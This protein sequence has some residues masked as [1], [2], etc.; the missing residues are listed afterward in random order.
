MF[1]IVTLIL[2]MDSTKINK[3]NNDISIPYVGPVTPAVT[4]A[5]PVTPVT[6]AKPATPV[7]PAV[8]VN[9]SGPV[10]PSG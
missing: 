3:I 5:K 10:T 9:P 2:Q 1:P 8:P 7:D 6:P 4:P